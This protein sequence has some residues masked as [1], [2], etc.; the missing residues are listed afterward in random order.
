M[1]V[2]TLLLCCLVS[3]IATAVA[4]ANSEK[5]PA[6]SPTEAKARAEESRA[7]KKEE[8][9]TKKK[10]I[11]KSKEW[12]K[13][14]Y[15]ELEKVWEDGDE[16]EELEMEY[17]RNRRIGE[18]KMKQGGM[19]ALNPDDPE[20]IKKFVK[21]QEKGGSTNGNPAMMFI[22]LPDEFEGKKWTPDSRKS[23]CQKWSTLLKS[24]AVDADLY[25][26]GETSLLINV[27]KGWL[28][29]DALKFILQ[30][31]EAVK[32]T[33]DSRDFYAKDVLDD[34]EL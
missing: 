5:G 16:E 9:R 14:N 18:K 23:L 4:Q 22:T 25:D 1:R 31:P 2:S 24:G 17:D 33:K 27:K 10:T 13:I 21:E 30:Q 15:N 28:V 34:D 32:V 26:I 6:L 11:K 29:R 7:K 3:Y 19:P 8:L 12:D 20:S